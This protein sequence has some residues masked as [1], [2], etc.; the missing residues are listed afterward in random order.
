MT[1]PWDMSILS[2]DYPRLAS[3]ATNIDASVRETMQVQNLDDIFFLPLS[4]QAYDEFQLLQSR[5]ENLPYD[6]NTTNKWAPIWGNMY[7]SHRFYWH[8]FS[9]V[10][11]HPIFKIIWKSRCTPRIKLFAW[12]VLVDQLNTKTMLWRRHLNI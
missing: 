5:L 2:Q 7:T 4:Q 3:F 11:A 8:V 1:H 12:L 6:D 9:E 10:D